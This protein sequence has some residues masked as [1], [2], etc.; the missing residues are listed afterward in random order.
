M[1]SLFSV[2]VVA[3]AVLLSP[4]QARADIAPSALA[5]ATD[6]QP[7]DPK[8]ARGI[9]MASEEVTVEL[10][11]GFAIVDVTFKMNNPG[12]ARKL[13]VGFPG[14]GVAVKQ[15]FAVHSALEAFSAWVDGKQIQTTKQVGEHCYEWRPGSKRRRTQTWHV[16]DVPFAAKGTTT[17]RV[18]YAV[19]S[20]RA[21]RENQDGHEAQRVHYILSTGAAW[22]GD[23]GEVVVRVKPN[24]GVLAS[25]VKVQSG[26]EREAAEADAGVVL[27]GGAARTG[28]DGVVV[29]RQTRLEPTEDDNLEIVYASV[30]G[31]D[32]QAAA[33]RLEAEALEPSTRLV[34]DPSCREEPAPKVPKKQRQ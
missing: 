6:L 20:D 18:R 12:K 15:G 23:I 22:K 28:E 27:A 32:S 5:N 26:R 21:Y 16:F 34:E 4:I 9:A 33:Q 3:A 29:R 14:E 10:H 13:E 11:H 25:S 19:E 2:S 24:D 1:R 7:M 31:K 8:E 30:P 17:V